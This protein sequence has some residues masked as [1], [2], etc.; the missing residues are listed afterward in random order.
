MRASLFIV[1]VSMMLASPAVLSTQS[2]ATTLTNVLLLDVP[3]AAS[4][5]TTADSINNSGEIAGSYEDLKVGFRVFTL[6][7][8]VFATVDPAGSVNGSSLVSLNNTGQ[9]LGFS[10]TATPPDYGSYYLASNGSFS[11]FPPPG[12]TLP[13]GASFSFYN[14]VGTIA[15]QTSTSAFIAQGGKI[16][17]IVPPDGIN[18]SINTVNNS[19]ALVGGYFPTVPPSPTANQEGFLLSNGVFTPLYV[20][21]SAFTAAVGI[22]DKGVVVGYYNLAQVTGPD[23]VP[24]TPVLGFSYFNGV[25]TSY[26]IAGVNTTELFG[27][28]NSGQVVGYERDATGGGHGFV[29]SAPGLGTSVPEPASLLLVAAGVLGLAGA[30]LGRPLRCSAS[31]HVASP[32]P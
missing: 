25:Y 30:S 10:N 31:R 2:R 26:D 21:G 4:G 28:N 20:P 32:R 18:V 24:F 29:A 16:T 11:A 8:G 19:N 27:I 5:T 1:P 17:T 12:T 15:G 22:N 7:N 6:T 13:V 9:V 14:D 3:G 23:G